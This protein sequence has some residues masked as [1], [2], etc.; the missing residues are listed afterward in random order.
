MPIM[1]STSSVCDTESEILSILS[2]SEENKTTED[3]FLETIEL[4]QM[5]ADEISEEI[6][7]S[8]EEVGLL[9]CAIWIICDAIPNTY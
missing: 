4:L 9:Q 8:I 2:S 6:S 3:D 5:D 1:A 7:C